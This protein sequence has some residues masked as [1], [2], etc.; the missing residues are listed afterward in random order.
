NM[1]KRSYLLSGLA[2]VLAL[3][4][5]VL[6]IGWTPV[7]A[8]GSGSTTRVSVAS[9]GA[10]SNGDASLPAISVNG[11]FVAFRSSADNLVSGDTNQ[12]LDIFVHDQ[13]T[14]ETT[15]ASLSSSGT[16]GNS[17]SDDPALSGSGR[18]VAFHSYASNLVS[19]DTNR[20]YDVFTHD[21][22]TGQTTRVSVNSAGTQGNNESLAPV[23]SG[24]GRYVAFYSYA[25]NLV[26]GDNNQAYDVF[27]HDR[28]TSQT[29][30]VSISSAGV[31]GCCD[32]Y[33]PSL[34]ISGRFVAFEGYASNLVSGDTN[35]ASDIFVHDRTTGQTTRLSVA[36]D[37]TQGN[38]D[39]SSAALSA[40]GR[41][42]AFRSLA[43]NLVTG[44]TNNVA[45]IFIHDRATGQT[46]RLSVASGGAEANGES[47]T[48]TLSA[49][50]RYVAFYS[51]ASN[52]VGND[53]NG[54]ADV[55]VHDRETGETAR[56]SV[57]SN[58]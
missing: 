43:S 16:Q 46:T 13:L 55:F 35:F 51:L 29:T 39:S 1:Q 24:S 57:A 47:Y 38:A 34:S 30:R 36:S 5:L 12:G 42:V 48:P 9:D 11:R 27:V 53:T 52:L 33:F 54:V 6:L 23:L 8:Q 32:S 3:G 28:T 25:T 17:L 10:Q 58:G 21:R 2:G 7:A 45:D 50:G 14:G 49:D 40:R 19:G 15:R 26:G 37:G 41:H 44:D 31:Q 18:Y 4:A 22:V 20:N 56:V